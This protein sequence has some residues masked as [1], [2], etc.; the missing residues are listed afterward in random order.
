MKKI[1][2]GQAFA[3]LANL[4]VVLGLILLVIEIEQSNDQAAA[5]AYQA[6]INEIDSAN[7]EFALSSDLHPIYVKLEQ[8]GLSSLSAEELLR[9]RA[10]ELARL[11]RMAGQH[12]QYHQGY[13]DQS[14]Y[15]AMMSNAQGWIGLWDDLGFGGATPEFFRDVRAYRE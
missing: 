10:W 6:R 1:D 11:Q 5:S 12:Y 13:L 9:V 14:A 8:T 4:G 7:Q 3:I 15:Q 2:L